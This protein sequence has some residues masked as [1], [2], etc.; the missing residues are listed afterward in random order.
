MR[1]ATR[2]G[3]WALCACAMV[4]QANSAMAQSLPAPWSSQDVGATGQTGSASYASGVFTVRG[5]GADIWG[6]ADAFRF[7]S[8]PSLGDAQIAAGVISLQ[9]TNT[10]AKAGVMF[11][12]D[13]RGGLRAR[14]P[15]RRPNGAIEFMTRPTTAAATTFVSTAIRYHPPG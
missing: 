9:N 7:V 10:F 14:D 12:T 1:N 15:R 5:A 3:S 11:A 2:A 8:Q 13:G 6:A 4:L